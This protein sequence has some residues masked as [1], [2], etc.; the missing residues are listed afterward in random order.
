MTYEEWKDAVDVELFRLCG[1]A[2]EDLPDWLSRDAYDEGLT[3]VEGAYQCL[4][5]AVYTE[6]HE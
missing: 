4:T 2:Q 6:Y 3:P 1:M 5:D